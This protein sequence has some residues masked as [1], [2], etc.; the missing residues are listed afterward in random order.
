MVNL[1]LKNKLINQ[2]YYNY[3]INVI[4]NLNLNKYNNLFDLNIFEML[5]NNTNVNKLKINVKE[6]LLTIFTKC[7][8]SENDL[9]YWINYYRHLNINF[10]AILTKTINHAYQSQ[11]RTWLRKYANLFKEW[12]IAY[13]H[14]TER[15]LKGT[16]LIEFFLIMIKLKISILDRYM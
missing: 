16:F 1:K 15:T 9:L 11:I 2:T 7:T 14:T 10:S 5:N 8:Y 12:I 6:V 13:K 4:N 3:I